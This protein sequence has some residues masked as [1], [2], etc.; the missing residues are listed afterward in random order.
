MKKLFIWDFHGTLE[1]GN[2]NAVVA[3]VNMALGSQG[4]ER[5]L[6]DEECRMLYGKKIWEFFQYLLPEESTKRCM[7]MQGF[8]LK[9]EQE[10]PEILLGHIKPNDGVLD[11]LQTIQ[12]SHHDQLLLSNT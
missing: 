2:E 8:F 12:N 1:K 6:N 7:E 9:A 4:Y 5:R 11:V 10:R 3:Y